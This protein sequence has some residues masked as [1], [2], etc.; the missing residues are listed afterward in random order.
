VPEQTTTTTGDQTQQ[1]TQTTQQTQQTSQQQTTQQQ[2][3]WYSSIDFG[4]A[5]DQATAALSSFKT[6]QELVGALDWR[7]NVAG[8]DEA[9]VKMFER[10]ATP[11]DLGKAYREAVKKISSGELAKPLPKDATPEQIAEWRKG[12]GIPEKPEG[13]FEKLPNGLV[14]GAEDKPMFDAVAAKFHARNVAPEAMHDLA[15]WYYGM[16]DEAVAKAAEKD[17][18]EAQAATDALRQDWGQD[19]RANI[20]VAMSFLDSLGGD[21][22]NQVMDA[23][24][25]DGTRLFN[26]TGFVKWIVAQAREANPAAHIVPSGSDSTIQSVQAEIAKIENVMRTNRAS[27]NQD[28]AMQER[29]RQL[30]DARTKLEQRGKAA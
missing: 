24:L 21:L 22:K 9:A 1:T 15:E 5:K 17:K 16:Q 23:T 6:P 19:Y 26:N 3:A 28:S 20:N 8:G 7:K 4:D 18:Q 30:Y 11:A 12:N 13:Y 29:L 2:A 27:Y 10:F 14:I 25:P